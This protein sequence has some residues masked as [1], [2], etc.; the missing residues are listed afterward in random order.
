[1]PAA[2]NAVPATDAASTTVQASRWKR[3]GRAPPS[4]TV[5][6]AAARMRDGVALWRK[7]AFRQP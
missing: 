5:P 1:M 6:G 3:L 7:T 4:L 2:T